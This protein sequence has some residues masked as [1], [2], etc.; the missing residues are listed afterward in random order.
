MMEM[1]KILEQKKFHR[2]NAFPVGKKKKS[3]GKWK[4]MKRLLTP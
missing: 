4:E 2:A 1:L 3:S